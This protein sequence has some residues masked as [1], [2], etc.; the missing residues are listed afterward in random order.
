M[1]LKEHNSANVGHAT[2][3]ATGSLR[4]GDFG[5]SEERIFMGLSQ[6]GDKDLARELIKI[7]LSGA[8][9]NEFGRYPFLLAVQHANSKAN[10]INLP[11]GRSEVLT[12]AQI[13]LWQAISEWLAGRTFPTGEA[14][15]T[16]EAAQNEGFDLAGRAR[17]LLSSWRHLR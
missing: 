17:E 10:D 14:R 8:A 3:F 12:L 7:A 9:Q 13:A 15:S 11:Y 1:F 6:K 4:D 2:L 5:K 16:I